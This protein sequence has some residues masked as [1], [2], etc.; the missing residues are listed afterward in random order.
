[1]SDWLKTLL[2]VD[3]T[4]IP[5]GASTSFEFANL[6]RGSAGLL[7]LL[8]AVVLIGGVFWI[9]RREGTASSRTKF[10]LATLRALVLLCA[11]ILILEPV[12]AVDQ[13]EEIDKS[14]IVLI[15]SSLSMT[16]K[17]RY[18]DA[19]ARAKIF[20]RIARNPAELMRYQIVNQALDKS[21]LI[22]MLARQN[23]V[24][25]YPFHRVIG[26]PQ[27]FERVV[28]NTPLNVLADVDLTTKEAR[29]EGAQGTD[30]G[31]AIRQAVEE[32]GSDRIA[33][34]IVISD[35]RTNLGAPAADV[36]LFLRN[37]D[38]RLHTVTVGQ[39][40]IPRNLR[41]VALAGPDRIFRNDPVSFEVQVSSQSYAGS[42]VYFE[43]RYTDG[44][45]DWAA[46]DSKVVGFEDSKKPVDLKF[47]DRPPRVGTV[48][49]RAYMELE[50]DESNPKDNEKT[51]PATVVDEKAKVLLVSGAPAHEYYAIKNV[52]LRDRTI[53]LASF[54][55]N[56]DPEFPQ[57]GNIS[58]KTLP[59]NEK[60]L[61]AFDV[62]ILHDPN[63]E[64]MPPNWPAMLKNFVATHRGGLCFVAG[65]K[66]TLNLVR[67]N[68]SEEDNDLTGLLP[69]VLDL[70]RADMPGIGVGYGGYF[71][72]PWRMVPEAAAFMHPA[73]RFGNPQRVRTLVWDRLPVFY[74]MF[75][76]LRAKPGATVLARTD[77]PR[78]VV[79]PYGARP[80]LA[81]QRFGGG[82]VMFL[83][84]DETHR[85][86]SVAEDVFD[87]FWIQSTRYL[88]EGR[89][90]GARRRFRVYLD[91]ELVDLGD[92]V[93]I[94]AEVFDE[95]FEPMETDAV[96]LEIL[97]PLDGEGTA[98]TLDLKL[99]AVENKPGHYTGSFSPPAPGD[100]E[101][102]AGDK[103][104]RPKPAEGPDSPAAKFAAELPDREMGDVRADRTLMGDIAAR[105]RGIAPGI[106][107][108]EK[109]SDEKLI[110]PAS[111]RVVTQGKPIPLWDTWTTI[112]VILTLLCAEWIL[113]KAYRMV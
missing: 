4:D 29:L 48:E 6:P 73:T 76:V 9:Y 107:E 106:H 16:T 34:I 64:K 102:R 61:F 113:R 15:D 91:R 80:V 38:L 86:R 108:L 7:L 109:L 32:V 74:W 65:N 72:T 85:W 28:D 14:T 77:D 104:Y 11:F 19:A 13:V 111:E 39:A 81:V 100:Y 21:D 18:A 78:E 103:R 35:G 44:S 92:A 110:P 30:L 94:Q 62:V 68:K 45:T 97:G 10:G 55:Q 58:L 79:E 90:A 63:G 66:F 25:V 51:F 88:L 46:I 5:E 37:K 69:V 59:Q 42:T 26:A 33:A 98:P 17:D 101:V 70:D 93:R 47:T 89:H 87:R 50:P 52:L 56:A 31:G 105:T 54:L 41:V 36:A 112:I 67:T 95:A 75:P 96:D 83:A 40:E 84:A 60:E 2:G 57:D 20:N 22:P 3:A 23:R 27:V 24:I 49:Y 71:E 43:R 82:R 99:V 53:Q 1:M 8:A 12:L